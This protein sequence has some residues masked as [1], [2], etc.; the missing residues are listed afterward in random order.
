[1]STDKTQSATPA[2]GTDPAPVILSPEEV[3]QQLRTLRTQL[4]LVDPGSLPV[5]P[6][7]RLAN[8]D[9]L[10]TAAS[11]NAAGAAEAVQ[12]ALGRS[13]ED[14]RQ[15]N[16]AAV[17]WSAVEDELRTLLANVTEMNTLRR[18]RVGLTALQTY[19]ICQQLARDNAHASRLD[20]HIA[21][22]RRLN[23]FGRG[24]KTKLQPPN[25]APAPTPAPTPAPAPQPTTPP[26][27]NT[28]PHPTTP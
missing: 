20:P 23:K 26:Q 12:S 18:Q 22:M 5:S 9:P 17:R 6:R 15:E 2:T 4:P 24:R 13:D 14:L 16:D 19:S 27:T 7:R 8:V 10:F 1:M 25:P 28:P 11:I 21:E 3:V